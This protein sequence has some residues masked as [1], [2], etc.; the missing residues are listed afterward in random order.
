MFEII[1]LA[2]LLYQALYYLQGFMGKCIVG[3]GLSLF[4]MCWNYIY[5]I[6]FD[7]LAGNCLW[8]TNNAYYSCMWL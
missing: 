3:I 5:N 2:I 4:A 1:A 8:S 7:K 6:I